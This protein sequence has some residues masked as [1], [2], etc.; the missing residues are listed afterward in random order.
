MGS[1]DLSLSLVGLGLEILLAA[2]LVRRNVHREFPFFFTYV[3]FAILASAARLSVSG[4]YQLYFKIFWV[5]ATLY[6]LFSL[7]ALYEVFRKVFSTC[8]QRW[9]WFRLVFP[10]TVAI[11]AFVQIWHAIVNPPIQ[12]SLLTAIILSF[13]RA[14]NLVETALFG[15]FFALAL[16]L[17][18]PGRSYPFSIVGGFGL[19][20]MGAVIAYVLRSGFGTKYDPLVKYA[21]LVAYLLGLLIWLGTFLLR[22]GTYLARQ[23]R[24]GALAG[25]NPIT[26][27]RTALVFGSAP[28]QPCASGSLCS[29]RRST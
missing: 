21:P 8:Y 16:L 11:A 25:G 13:G 19:S 26:H 12:A 14:I 29:K 1:L 10:G 22:D 24:D 23:D 7:L 6:A 15:L 17:G 28:W 18:V 3:A 20:A 2:T 5:T 27:K 4:D 9:W